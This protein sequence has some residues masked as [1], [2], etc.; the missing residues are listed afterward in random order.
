M[1]LVIGYIRQHRGAILLF[2]L[3]SLLF[4]V[5]FF[6]F[7]LPVVAVV[8]AAAIC[9]FL[10]LVAVLLDFRSYARRHRRLMNLRKEI[11]IS[12][13]H[14]PI[15]AGPIEEDYQAL[16]RILFAEK[17]RLCD[18]MTGRYTD[19]VDSYTLWA[20]QIKTPIASMRLRLQSEDSPLSR[21]ISEDLVRIEQY[22]EMAL[23]VLRLDSNS[24][25]YLIAQINLDKIVKQAVRRFASQFIRRKIQLE[26]EEISCSVL[27]DEKWLLFVIE[28]LLSNALKYTPSGGKIAVR[29]EKPKILAISDTG[30]G[31]APEDLPRVFQK[32]YTGYNG[33]SDKKASGLGLYL[34]RRICENLGHRIWVSS[35]LESG[36]VVRIDLSSASL[37]VE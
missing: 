15:A 6:L 1:R 7:N 32:G 17:Q 16:L 29:L 22:V 31:I 24:T 33:R 36:T 13:D 35:S 18:E 27:T 5:T 26:M 12:C 9:G 11:K 8:Y 37:E 2:F 19:L 10:G 21:E 4:L 23:V 14:L 28:Q 25:D 3:F 20:H 30:I 34:C